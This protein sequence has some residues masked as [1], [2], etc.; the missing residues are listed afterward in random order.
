VAFLTVALSCVVTLPFAAFN[1]PTQMPGARSLIA[2]VFLGAVMTALAFVLYFKLIPAIGAGRTSLVN[3]TAPAV[4]LV[5]GAT[6]LGEP[7]SIPA[8]VGLVL[9]ISG[10]LAASRASTRKAKIQ[11]ATATVKPPC[12]EFP[13]TASEQVRVKRGDCQVQDGAIKVYSNKKREGTVSSVDTVEESS[14]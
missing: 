5:Y 8:I 11:Q 13:R 9:V 2:V 7:I 12:S 1:L 14:V 10:M 3:Y 4:A 6:L